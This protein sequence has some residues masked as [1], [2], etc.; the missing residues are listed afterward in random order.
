VMLTPPQEDAGIA[1][2][3]GNQP[4]ILFVV[5]VGHVL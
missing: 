4:T 2:T 1:R 5:W 3:A